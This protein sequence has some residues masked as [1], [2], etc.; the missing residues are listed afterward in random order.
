MTPDVD[1]Q[2]ETTGVQPQAG[3]HNIAIKESDAT[4]GHTVPPTC[5]VLTSP[6]VKARLRPRKKHHNPSAAA[7]A[8]S[9]KHQK[10]KHKSPPSLPARPVLYARNVRMHGTQVLP[11]YT[12]EK[13]LS[14][15]RMSYNV[16]TLQPL[17]RPSVQIYFT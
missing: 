3:D 15:S 9:A 11:D 17:V 2:R 1:I 6:H 13:L 7:T 14:Q 16:K 4:P 10:Q 5:D 12:M 8:E